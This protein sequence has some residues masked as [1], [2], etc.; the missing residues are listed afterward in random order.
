M[1]DLIICVHTNVVQIHGKLLDFRLRHQTQNTKTHI[2]A[3]PPFPEA[4]CDIMSMT[5]D[6]YIYTYTFVPTNLPSICKGVHQEGSWTFLFGSV[7]E[8]LVI[9]KK[10]T[11]TL[12]ELNSWKLRPNKT[13]NTNR[14][15]ITSG[16][17][18]ICH[19]FLRRQRTSTKIK[20]N[21]MHHGGRGC[22][23]T[24]L[25]GITRGLQS[26][27]LQPGGPQTRSADFGCDLAPTCPLHRLGPTVWGPTVCGA[28]GLGPPILD[29]PMHSPVLCT[30]W[31]HT[32]WGPT[33]SA[34][35]SGT[36]QC[37]YMSFG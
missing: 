28:H 25:K 37:T 2:I 1:C 9:H 23:T 12:F 32:I 20:D 14:F 21:K 34:H 10:C 6:I 18:E 35:R 15:P 29:M 19:S 5:K 3:S 33:D 27:G 22:S 31:G 17:P 7:A 11:G 13:G 26:G 16:Y 8:W 24:G 30:S 36:C 4:M